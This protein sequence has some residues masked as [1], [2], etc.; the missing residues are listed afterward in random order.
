MENGHRVLDFPE[1]SWLPRGVRMPEDEGCGE[2]VPSH[3]SEETPGQAWGEHTSKQWQWRRSQEEGELQGKAV[4]D[5]GQYNY[6]KCQDLMHLTTIVVGNI[7]IL[8]SFVLREMNV[9]H[10]PFTT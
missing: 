4:D 8:I 5:G 9:G 7:S 10:D 6:I 2:D 3:C 1:D